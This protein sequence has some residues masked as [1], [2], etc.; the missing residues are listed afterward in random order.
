MKTYV[1]LLRGIN[2]GGKNKISMALLKECLEKE[3]FTQVMTY[4]QS[5]NVLVDSSLKQ[6]EIGPAIERLLSKNFALDSS[7]IKTL[8]LTDEQ[9]KA[10]I[11]N[12]PKGFGE[13]PETYHSDV[14]F[15]MNISTEEAIE[16][17]DPKEGVDTI[18][19]GEGVVYSQRLSELREEVF[20]EV[21]ND[22]EALR[23]VARLPAVF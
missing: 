11:S 21:V 17:F 18:W 12:K 10:V 2:V 19:P 20:V 4:I 1:V 6:V 7:L 15:L 9:I 14:I 22:D 23:G 3:G 8:V 13:H 16:A 5:G